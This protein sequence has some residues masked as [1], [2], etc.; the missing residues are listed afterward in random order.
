[1]S[2]IEQKIEVITEFLQ[3]QA[4]LGRLTNPL[5]VQ[6]AAG[7][8]LAE[9]GYR[10]SGSCQPV[11]RDEVGLALA[12]IAKTSFAEDGIIL[13]ALVVH[14]EDKQPG[15]RFVAQ[16]AEAG[17]VEVPVIDPDGA[18]EQDLELDDNGVPRY[19]VTEEALSVWSDQVLKVFAKY[20]PQ[21][22][23]A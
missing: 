13:P 12:Q 4:R 3:R 8:A 11:S 18:N 6:L 23:T 19:E 15:H 5:E 2:T 20:T 10:A 9:K 7:L 1:M 14:F 16:A 21:E 22:V 17:L